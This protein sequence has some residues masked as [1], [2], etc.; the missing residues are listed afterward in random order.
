VET[1]TTLEELGARLVD[2]L[3]RPSATLLDV[4]IDLDAD[5]AVRRLLETEP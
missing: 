3:A 5:G 2:A 4:R 1:P